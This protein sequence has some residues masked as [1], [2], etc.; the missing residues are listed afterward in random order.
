MGEIL[1]QV[2]VMQ[3]RGLYAVMTESTTVYYVS[4]VGDRPLFIRARGAG[5]TGWGPRDGLWVQLGCLRS[6]R[7]SELEDLLGADADIA[8]RAGEEWVLQVG[9]RHFYA[10]QETCSIPIAGDHWWIQRTCERIERVDAIPEGLP[11][12]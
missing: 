9:N 2:D 5:R 6:V 10:E 8:Q 4:T 7:D 1:E 3:N 11:R 12:P